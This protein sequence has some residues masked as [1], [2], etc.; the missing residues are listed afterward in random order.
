MSGKL[1]AIERFV[2]VRRDGREVRAPISNCFWCGPD[3][4][5]LCA[6]CHAKAQELRAKGHGRSDFVRLTFALV[7]S[8]N[9]IAGVIR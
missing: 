7:K 3:S 1:V 5:A 6:L 8:T 4:D 2:I 9:G